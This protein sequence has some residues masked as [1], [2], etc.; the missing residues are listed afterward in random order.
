MAPEQIQQDVRPATSEADEK[1]RTFVQ[2]EMACQLDDVIFRRTA[3]GTIGHPGQEALGKCADMMGELL[4]WDDSEK[5]R[6]IDMVNLR[7]DY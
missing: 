3:V 4:G 7:Y 5:Q 2:H 1:D 6:Q